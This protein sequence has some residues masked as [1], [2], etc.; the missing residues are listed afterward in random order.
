MADQRHLPTSQQQ[1]R[2]TWASSDEPSSALR[3]LEDGW[4]LQ[5]SRESDRLAPTEVRTERTAPQRNPPPS[6]PLFL[7]HVVEARDPSVGMGETR[8]GAT[9]DR[10]AV[11]DRMHAISPDSRPP[12]HPPSPSP[13]PNPKEGCTRI[14]CQAERAWCGLSVCTDMCVRECT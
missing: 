13:S 6:P 4:V 8:M 11:P 5:A 10:R 7:S 1:R 3:P 14:D 2:V 9:S 12:D